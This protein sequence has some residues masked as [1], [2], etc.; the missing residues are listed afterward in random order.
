MSSFTLTSDR[1][2]R[3]VLHAKL[4]GPYGELHPSKRLELHF[5]K[6]LAAAQRATDQQHRRQLLRRLA[7]SSMS[8]CRP[9]ELGVQTTEDHG[10][11]YR[12][13][14]RRDLQTDDGPCRCHSPQPEGQNAGGEREQIAA[15][16]T[17]DDKRESDNEINLTHRIGKRESM[18]SGARRL[19]T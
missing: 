12:G 3:S 8:P 16:Q 11:V 9:S 4:S 6:R 13:T 1:R 14:A 17:N 10:K 7:P 2:K 5:S 18:A 15:M 19:T